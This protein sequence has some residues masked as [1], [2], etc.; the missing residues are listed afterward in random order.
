MS[1]D[2]IPERLI[3]VREHLGIT[4]AE[5]SRRMNL[6]QIGYCRYEYGERVPSPQMT[7]VIA[8]TLQTSVAYLTGESEDMAPDTLVINQTENPELFQL[9]A[10]CKSNKS[11]LSSRLLAYAAELLT[12]EE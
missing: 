6:S 1:K 7:E 3:K 12:A 8:Q 4:K 11:D 2:L 9:A 10:L 5:A